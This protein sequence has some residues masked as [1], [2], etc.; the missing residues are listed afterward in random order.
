MS[1]IDTR[2]AYSRLFDKEITGVFSEAL[3]R[4]GN[5]T[6]MAL[7]LA[8]TLGHQRRAVKR[9][10]RWE[11]V[12]VHVPPLIICSVTNRCNLRCPGCYA[13]AHQ[14]PQRPD[15]NV[16]QLEDIFREAAELG[17]S[18]I[19][20]AGGEP[21]L[22]EGVIEAAG[23]RPEIIFPV[24][25]NGSLLDDGWIERLARRRNVIPAL[26]LE[27]FCEKTDARRGDGTYTRTLE[28]VRRLAAADVFCAVSLTLTRD[29]FAECTGDAFAAELTEAGCRL[30]FYV[31]YVPV[32]AGTEDQVLGEELRT[33]M[34]ARLA[35][36][37]REHQALFI[38]F[39]GDEEPYEGC[40][41]AG[42]GFL[43][44]GPDGGLEPCPFSPYS[45]VDLGETSLR[46]ALQSDFLEK[47]RA[48]H[49]RMTESEGGCALW[50]HRDWVQ[51]LLRTEVDE[52]ERERA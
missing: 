26:S 15:L 14:R 34:I 22:R 39:P 18:V 43:H 28:L 48:A 19:F 6:R 49:D 40:L 32:K 36:L 45:D 9:R 13:A 47:V 33:R 12:G 3:R 2:P 30:F 52:T 35:E 38:A 25:T 8:R 20:L 50:T 4:A 5:K 37:Q 16:K 29:N 44:I 24:F 27:G 46:E 7:F 1:D 10:V 51:S 31:E 17:V 23:E 42:R 41:S 11:A 21:F